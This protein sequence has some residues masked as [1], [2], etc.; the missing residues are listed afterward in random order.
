MAIANSAVNIPYEPQPQWRT[1]GDD[2][3]TLLMLAA[4]LATVGF[5]SVEYS[6]CSNLI[7]TAQSLEHAAH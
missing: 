7:I 6:K 4:G 5:Q 2:A 1:Q 3:R